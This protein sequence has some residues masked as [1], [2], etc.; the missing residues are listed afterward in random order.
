MKYKHQI[1]VRKYGLMLESGYGTL[2]PPEIR[3]TW[4]GGSFRTQYFLGSRVNIMKDGVGIVYSDQVN[5][6][7]LSSPVLVSVVG[8]FF[9]SLKKRG[10]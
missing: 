9:I 5:C 4:R 2:I 3:F 7:S 8:R 6:K 10:L 1:I